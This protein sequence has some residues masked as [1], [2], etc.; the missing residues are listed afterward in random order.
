MRTT[1][2]QLQELRHILELGSRK[3]GA[4]DPPKHSADHFI[5]KSQRHLARHQIGQL[6]DDESS[7]LHLLHA[8]ADLIL[9]ACFFDDT[10]T[11]YSE[12]PAGEQEHG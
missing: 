1:A 4:D 10:T 2:Q 5:N 3:Y 12:Q 9:A 8:A 6:H 11:R 7:R